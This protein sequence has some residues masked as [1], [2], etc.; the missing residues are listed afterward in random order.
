MSFRL[1]GARPN[2]AYLR[3]KKYARLGS[4]LCPTCDIPPLAGSTSPTFFVVTVA[5]PKRLPYIPRV[6]NRHWHT[7]GARSRTTSLGG[8]RTP[9]CPSVK[10]TGSW[11]SMNGSDPLQVA[12]RG[13]LPACIV[14][15]VQAIQAAPH[16]QIEL[17]TPPTGPGA[18]VQLLA[19]PDSTLIATPCR[20]R[21]IFQIRLNR[22]SSTAIECLAPLSHG[23]IWPFTTITGSIVVQTAHAEYCAHH[24]AVLSIALNP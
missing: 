12:T 15:S 4:F 23:R 11:Q 9:R 19:V 16:D 13:H 7:S 1:V 3:S 14:G 10:P 18:T 8:S 2:S 17:I 24:F 21:S 22:H 6:G 5:C 20:A